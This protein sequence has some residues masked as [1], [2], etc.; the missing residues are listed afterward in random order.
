VTVK[1]A[2]TPSGMVE[3]I[4]MSTVTSPDIESGLIRDD[5]KVRLSLV[6]VNV[7]Q[8]ALHI[9][10]VNLH[11]TTSSDPSTNSPILSTALVESPFS[12]TLEIPSLHHLT[13]LLSKSAVL[14]KTLSSAVFTQPPALKHESGRNN[15]MCYQVLVKLHKGMICV[16]RFKLNITEFK[17]EVRIRS[18]SVTMTMIVY[19]TTITTNATLPIPPSH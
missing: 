12:S 7:F 8:S 1:K 16:D 17:M 4:H 14:F 2:E 10:L 11:L 9:P 3:G 15:K 5:S 19:L 18:N 13:K 6:T